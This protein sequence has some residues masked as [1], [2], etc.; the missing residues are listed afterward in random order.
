V[1]APV[2]PLRLRLRRIEKKPRKVFTAHWTDYAGIKAN[3]A[4]LDEFEDIV[5]SIERG[6]GV[7]EAHHRA[8]IDVD[9]DD[10]L[11][12]KGIMHLHLGG[13]DSDVLVFRIQYADRVVLLETNAHIHCR[14]EPAGKNILAPHQ[15]WLGP[16]EREMEQA[17]TEAKTAA[18][19][20]EQQAAEVR[21]RKSLVQYRR[22]SARQALDRAP[23]LSTKQLR[24]E[25][26][27]TPWF[28]SG[29]GELIAITSSPAPAG[30]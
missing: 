20:E 16:L 12:Q 3:P 4:L 24:R 18:T 13:Q 26:S 28:H 29:P 6:D 15:S 1:R 23:D 9:S 19:E 25:P 21:R 10:L 8:G 22:S 11:A 27:G 2:P 17:A 14:T 5:E 7:P 30:A